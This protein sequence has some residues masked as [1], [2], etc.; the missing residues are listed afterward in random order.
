MPLEY[1]PSKEKIP[2][3]FAYPLK[4]TDIDETLTDLA[5]Q[6]VR[7]SF[8]RFLNGNRLDPEH[9]QHDVR[10]PCAVVG[11]RYWNDMW[12]SAAVSRHKEHHASSWHLYICAIPSVLRHQFRADCVSTHLP[13]LGRLITSTKPETWFAKNRKRTLYFDPTERTLSIKNEDHL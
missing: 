1:D 12:A 7:V 11:L 8:V 6:T 13:E 5:D 4:R 3:G 10:G 9:W 2:S